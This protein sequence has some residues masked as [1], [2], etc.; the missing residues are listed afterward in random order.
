MPLIT[1]SYLSQRARWPTAGRHILCQHDA[2]SVVVYQ[3]YAPSIGGFAARHGFFGGDFKLTRMSW[4]KPNFLWMMY[5]CGWATKVNQ[6]TVLAVWLRRDAFESV[7]A[8]AV[9][10]T[11]IPEVYGSR[12]AWQQQVARSDVRL[13]W[14]PDH[15]PSGAPE[16]RRAIQLGLQGEVLRRYAKEWILAIEDI[17]PF[18]RDQHRYSVQR[19]IDQ[20]L[21]PYET[22]F[23]PAD[24]ATVRRLGLDAPSGELRAQNDPRFPDYDA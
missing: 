5:R 7:L 14:D 12:E 1:E 18:V 20:L 22:V 23:S 24:E 17:T 6:E 15:A 9:H 19:Q 16:K 8:Q 13:Q 21:T 10:S 4:I 11:Y 2:G 3:A